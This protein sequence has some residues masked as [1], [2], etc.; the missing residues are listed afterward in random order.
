[1]DLLSLRIVEAVGQ[2][3]WFW[4]TGPRLNSQFVRHLVFSP[5]P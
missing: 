5:P 1:M 4:I 3:I 2:R